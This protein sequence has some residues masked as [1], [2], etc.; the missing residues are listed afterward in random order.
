MMKT[1]K[2]PQYMSDSKINT[3]QLT[4]SHPQANRV[5]SYISLILYTFLTLIIGL[6]HAI[7]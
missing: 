4:L 6:G 5:Q 3:R 7:H 2:R 1:N